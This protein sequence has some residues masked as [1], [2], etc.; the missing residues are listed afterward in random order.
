MLTMLL[1]YILVATQAQCPVNVTSIFIISDRTI[2]VPLTVP[3]CL[4]CRFLNNMGDRIAFN[5]GT[6]ARGMGA[7]SV[8]LTNG[9]FNGNITLSSTSDTTFITLT[10]PG[11]VVN[12]GDVLVCSSVQAN[13]QNI[14]TIGAFSNLYRT[15]NMSYSFFVL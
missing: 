3:L 13:A 2:N 8:T 15:H 12:V 6:W 4:A 11:A 9:S 1:S 14:L 5:D 7:G 10:F